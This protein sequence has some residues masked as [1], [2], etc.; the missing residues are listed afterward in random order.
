MLLVIHMPTSSIAPGCMP[1][2]FDDVVVDMEMMLDGGGAELH[3]GRPAY[4]VA[5]MEI[6]PV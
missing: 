1:G 3:A 2:S 4:V 5:G 6:A